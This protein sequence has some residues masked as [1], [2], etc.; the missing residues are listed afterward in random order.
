MFAIA[1]HINPR[2]LKLR[3]GVFVFAIVLHV[4]VHRTKPPVITG[5]RDLICNAIALHV[6]LQR[7]NLTEDSSLLV[8]AGLGAKLFFPVSEY[9]TQLQVQMQRNLFN[10]ALQL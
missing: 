7:K 5:V 8:G 4:P 9:A 3:R 2:I 1:V 10:Y 6:L